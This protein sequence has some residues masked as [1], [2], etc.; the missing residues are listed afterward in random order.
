MNSAIKR[1]AVQGG[2]ARLGSEDI[3]TTQK[4]GS[5]DKVDEGDIID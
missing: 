1:R 4:T 5:S 2:L 3:V